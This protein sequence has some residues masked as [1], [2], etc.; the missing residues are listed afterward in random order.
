[1]D[2]NYIITKLLPISNTEQ[3]ALVTTSNATSS[4][5][6]IVTG[7]TS[8]IVRVTNI[9]FRVLILYI[10]STGTMTP[11]DVRVSSITSIIPFRYTAWALG[12]LEVS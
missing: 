6:S 1:M 4:N 11:L 3:N 2:S 12:A 8:D 9:K 5:V 10:I 7:E